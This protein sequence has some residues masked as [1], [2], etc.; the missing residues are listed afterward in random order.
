MDAAGLA[1]PHLLDEHGRA[2]FVVAKAGQ[3]TGLTF[4]R[5]SALEAYTCDAAGR[6]SWEV[7]VLNFSKKRGSFARGGDSGAAV[8]NGE[9]RLVAVVHSGMLRGAASHVAFG[10]P[11]H[12]VVELIRERYPRADFEC[13]ASDA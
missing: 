8:F 1:D 3:A 4:G 10:T 12:Y 2:G 7:A 5:L 6:A 13:R 9:G 11:G